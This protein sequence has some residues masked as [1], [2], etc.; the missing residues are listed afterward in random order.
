MTTHPYDIP[1]AADGTEMV[2]H[3]LPTCQNDCNMDPFFH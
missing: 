3:I 1:C 2:G